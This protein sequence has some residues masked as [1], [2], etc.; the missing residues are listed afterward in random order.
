[1]YNLSQYVASHRVS[2]SLENTFPSPPSFLLTR[3]ASLIFCA[4]VGGG[5]ALFL[6]MGLE[7]AKFP[8]HQLRLG[9]S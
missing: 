9:R 6:I 8:T 3:F 2:L 7:T 1:M 4:G 5:E